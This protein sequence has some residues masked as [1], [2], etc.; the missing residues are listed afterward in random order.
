MIIER[1]SH[2]MHIVSEVCGQIRKDKDGF[3][4]LK[5]AFPAGTVAGAPKIR[6]M[7]II[8]DLEKD[9]RGPYAGALG[10]FSYSGDMD[11]AITIRTI[12]YDKGKISIQTGA[13]IVADSVP[14]KEYQET[15][16]KAAGVKKTVELA[17]SGRLF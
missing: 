5:A 6:A 10:Y 7:E 11:M 8:D 1:Y 12:L 16:N 17:E 4:L 14:S 15:E 2:V 9:Q 3:D 13:G